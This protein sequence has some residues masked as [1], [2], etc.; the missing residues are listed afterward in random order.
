VL[1]NQTSICGV[2]FAHFFGSG[3]NI[4]CKISTFLS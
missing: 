2:S 4:F 1:F 3:S